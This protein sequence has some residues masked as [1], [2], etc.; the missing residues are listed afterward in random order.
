MDAGKTGRLI[1][2]RRKEKGLKQSELA[3]LIHVSD[4]AVSKYENGKRFPDISVLEDLAKAL[5]L[6][7]TELITGER[8]E[9]VPEKQEK[10]V[11]EAL[12]VSAAQNRMKS[13]R[14]MGILS[15]IFGMIIL[16]MVFYPVWH[17]PE[18]IRLDSNRTDAV[19]SLNG[20][21][22][23]ITAYVRKG[24]STVRIP[25]ENFAS[26]PAESVRFVHISADAE[27]GVHIVGGPYRESVGLY[28]DSAMPNYID[29]DGEIKEIPPIPM[30]W[31][32]S[33]QVSSK[34]QI[35][36]ID[37]DHDLSASLSSCLENGDFAVIVTAKKH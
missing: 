13:K 20:S 8:E 14:N 37:A 27:W 9:D 17:M 29:E 32:E 16:I 21:F 24:S 33:L 30:K 4:T 7:L 12:R 31:A 10:A 1:A 36:G 15:A 2:E 5:D 23:D 19:Y 3:A 18:F 22:I 25:L 11:A 6:T 35:L 26:L 28:G 34:E